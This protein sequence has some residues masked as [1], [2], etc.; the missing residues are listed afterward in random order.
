[1]VRDSNP[2][3]GEKG[4]RPHQQWS[5]PS[6]LIS[7]Y[8]GINLTTC[9]HLVPRL[10]MSGVI[11]CITSICMRDVDAENFTFAFIL[12]S[13]YACVC[14][15]V[16]AGVRACQVAQSVQRLTTGWTVRDR[17]PVGTNFP[18]VKTGPGAHLAS[19]KMGTGSFPG[20]KCGRGVLLTTHSLLVP[21]SRK[22]RAVPLHTL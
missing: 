12:A 22:S 16:R 21:R 13:L 1:M 5:L 6:F 9:G 11:P 18:P 7:G 15:R 10:R 14:V 4:N 3:G 8:R 20:V 2:S 17:I 19:C